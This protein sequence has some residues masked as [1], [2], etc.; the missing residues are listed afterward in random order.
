MKRI[1]TLLIMS[2]VVLHVR[3]QTKSLL[4]ESFEYNA[5]GWGVFSTCS[6]NWGLTTAGASDGT[7]S[8]AYGSY[9]SGCSGFLVSP[10]ITISSYKA[11]DSIYMTFDFYRE[12][13]DPTSADYMNVTFVSADSNFTT[14]QGPFEIDRLYNGKPASTSAGWVTYNG[15]WPVSA[16]LDA[17]GQFKLVFEGVTAGKGDYMFLDNVKLDMGV[18]TT[19]S[20]VSLSYIQP[21]GNEYLYWGENYTV[22]WISSSTDNMS[23]KIVSTD[24]ASTIASGTGHMNDASFSFTVPTTTSKTNFKVVITDLSTNDLF[25]SNYFQVVQPLAL[26]NPTGGETYY[27]GQSVTISWTSSLI[28][29]VDLYLKSSDGTIINSWKSASS[30]EHY[31]IIIPATNKSNVYIDAIDEITGQEVAT[32]SF[33]IDKP[34]INFLSPVAGQIY[35]NNNTMA[36]QWSSNGISDIKADAKINLQLIDSNGGVVQSITTGN[37]I[38]YNAGSY[39]WSVPRI[40]GTFQIQATFN[41]SAISQMLKYNSGRVTLEHNTGMIENASFADMNVY[42]NPSYGAFNIQ[43]KDAMA[44]N[45]I[46]TV[47]SI[48]GRQVMEQKLNKGDRFI[49]ADINNLAGIYTLYIKTSNTVMHSQIM[50]VSGR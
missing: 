46:L 9:S 10:T 13:S 34:T 12:T 27:W 47:Y 45:G 42:P 39:N 37:G 23:I 35:L 44:E 15:K 7:H 17:N 5:S 29:T 32:P 18:K 43:L 50:F 33:T 28:G 2:A 40:F 22:K 49:H 8:A 16:L 24:N 31:K 14:L 6:D 41:D 11:S 48:D 36:I 1:F 25:I 3:A 19:S 20:H 38:P 30:D 21:T 26:T 4:S